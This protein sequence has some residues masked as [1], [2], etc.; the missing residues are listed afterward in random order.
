MKYLGVWHDMKAGW[1][2]QRAASQAKHKQLIG[3][4]ERTTLSLEMA[5]CAINTVIIPTLLYAAQVAVLPRSMLDNW[6]RAHRRVAK[7]LGR[8]PVSMPD[9]IMHLSKQDGGVGLKSMV[10]EVAIAK[11]KL[12]LQA[13]NDVC[14]SPKVRQGESLL[15]K[16]VRAGWER[17][18]TSPGSEHMNR[19][20]SCCADI[21]ASMSYLHATVQRTPAAL[22]VTNAR[23][24]DAVAAMAVVPGPDLEIY[25]DG[26]TATTEDAPAAGWGW[27]SF[28]KRDADRSSW[29]VVDKDAGRLHG[30]Q[31]NYKAESQAALEALLRTHPDTPVTL[32]IDN[33][34][35]VQRFGVN[36]DQDPR[37][38]SQCSARAVWNRISGL[39]LLREARRTPTKVAW[40]H[41][42]VNEAGS[43]AAGRSQPAVGPNGGIRI[44]GPPCAC[45]EAAG[46]CDAAHNHHVGNAQ[47]DL[48]ADEGRAQPMG[49]A[50]QNLCGE[51]EY[52]VAVHGTQ[53]EGNITT[54]LRGAARQTR[55]AEM[56][57]SSK[58][59]LR[60][61][62]AMLSRSDE[63]VRHR[64]LKTKAVSHRFKVRAIAGM[65]PTHLHEFKR[66]RDGNDYA[67]IYADTITGGKCICALMGRCTP[68]G[69]C[70]SEVET[71]EH[72]MAHCLVSEDVHEHARDRVRALWADGHDDSEAATRD[73]SSPP[74]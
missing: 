70:C 8:L 16:V 6:D 10:D 31:K 41:S 43:A 35:V 53:C 58:P 38:R 29:A 39:M 2:T 60:R 9:A 44:V 72:A 12:D 22:A 1:E 59:T 17:H 73:M 36:L 21:K 56:A 68:L 4:L 46:S 18:D 51:E 67:H 32:Y 24:L 11:V 74:A 15:A 37:G 49:R 69:C 55:L 71:M 26:S 28:D 65:L 25:T 19:A 45:G 52:V 13:R 3:K 42:H 5:V 20:A 50:E 14:L 27:I 66:L 7:K 64:V 63:A 61:V 54:D 40:V 47:A 30:A 48:L 62:H 34:S 57:T 33:L 23:A